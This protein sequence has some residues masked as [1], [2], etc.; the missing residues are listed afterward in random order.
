MTLP[1]GTVV[2]SDTTPTETQP[3]TATNLF[4]DADG[5]TGAVF[6][7]QWQQSALGGGG[8]FTDIAGATSSA[9]SPARPR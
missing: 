6:S 9:S 2:I 7:Y 8:P 3:I 1:V 5:L 4:T